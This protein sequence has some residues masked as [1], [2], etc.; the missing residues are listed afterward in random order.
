MSDF[1]R[2]ELVMK[3]L[4]T[5]LILTVCSSL[6]TSPLRACDYGLPWFGYGYSGSLYGLGYVP[7]PP[8]FALHPPVQY[9]RPVAHAYGGSPFAARPAE[10]VLVEPAP[11]RWITNPFVSTATSAA[12]STASPQPRMIVNP[13]YK[14]P[15]EP[16]PAPPPA[17]EPA[18]KEGEKS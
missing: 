11:E 16:L 8:Y 13:Y 3:S 5:I 10:R 9:S 14:K 15:A 18:P 6:A 7:V 2:E 17:S 4:G 1:P 12:A